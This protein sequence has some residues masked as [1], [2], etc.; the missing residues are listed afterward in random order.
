ML[1][2]DTFKCSRDF[3]KLG[4]RQ[5][6][7]QKRTLTNHFQL[8]CFHGGDVGDFPQASGPP[9]PPAGQSCSVPDGSAAC[10]QN[11]GGEAPT[12]PTVCSH[13]LQ[14]AQSHPAASALV[15]WG[16]GPCRFPQPTW[17]HPTPKHQQ[18]M[19]AQHPKTKRGTYPSA[20]SECQ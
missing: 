6:C 5:L 18:G 13:S 15:H 3:S 16:G 12:H 11:P 2:C 1:A 8:G 10:I 19:L 17:R 4:K 20:L 14:A 9:F 7:L